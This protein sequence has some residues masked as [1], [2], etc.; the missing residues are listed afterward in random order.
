MGCLS[1]VDVGPSKRSV[2]ESPECRTKATTKAIVIVIIIGDAREIKNVRVAVDT[3]LTQRSG[4]VDMGLGSSS[5]GE[6]LGLS[7]GFVI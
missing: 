4:S 1:D 6:A 7:F 3:H 2:E 5:S